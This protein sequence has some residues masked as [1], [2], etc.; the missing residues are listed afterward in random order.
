MSTFKGLIKCSTCSSKFIDKHTHPFFNGATNESGYTK[1]KKS[2]LVNHL[3]VHHTGA[4]RLK[5]ADDQPLITD[6]MADM[7]IQKKRKKELSTSDISS[8]QEAAIDLIASAGIPLKLIG[9]EEFVNF[10]KVIWEKSTGNADDVDKIPL[11]SWTLKRRMDENLAK[12]RQE[13]RDIADMLAKS[14]HLS[15]GFDHHH[16]GSHIGKYRVNV[17]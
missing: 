5:P 8:I 4:K 1:I 14:G 12:N 11:S 2:L 3:K 7:V 13:F 6:H 9:S 16:A 10:L 17:K 15:I